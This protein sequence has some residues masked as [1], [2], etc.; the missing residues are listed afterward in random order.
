MNLR[1]LRIIVAREDG[2]EW[3]FIVFENVDLQQFRSTSSSGGGHPRREMM[4]ALD[5]LDAW[6]VL[7]SFWEI[8][9][10]PEVA[11][12][13]DSGSLDDL[14]SEK[15]TI[16]WETFDRN[17]ALWHTRSEQ[18]KEESSERSETGEN[19]K[20]PRPVAIAIRGFNPSDTSPEDFK[21]ELDAHQQKVWDYVGGNTW[22]W[23]SKGRTPAGYQ[24]DVLTFS[25]SE[26]VTLGPTSIE[27]P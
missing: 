13:W 5:R 1:A 10:E 7:Q 16:M 22:K 21:K 23:E 12:Y 27:L 4:A 11:A 6:K 14:V 15:A 18:V 25:G 17:A 8:S 3:R 2:T 26:I 24:C 9:R 19:A 20:G